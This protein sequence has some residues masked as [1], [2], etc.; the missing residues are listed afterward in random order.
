MRVESP[1]ALELLH[2]AHRARPPDDLAGLPS[3]GDDEDV[4]DDLQLLVERCGDLL[5]RS[6]LTEAVDEVAGALAFGQRLS[7]LGI[8]GDG[9]GEEG[10]ARQMGDQIE[11]LAPTTPAP[12]IS[13][14]YPL[15]REVRFDR[16]AVPLEEE[17]E[18][19]ASPTFKP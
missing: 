12:Q 5:P 13:E 10:V 3:I 7:E 4:G 1:L 8:F 18:A 2:G 16:P 11:E 17:D 19:A 14:V 15:E 6:P 9:L